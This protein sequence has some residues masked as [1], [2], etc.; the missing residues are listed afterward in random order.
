MVCTR[1]AIATRIGILQSTHIHAFLDI[2][3]TH[4][5]ILIFP[6]YFTSLLERVTRLALLR[7]TSTLSGLCCPINSCSF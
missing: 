4:Q 5:S 7:Q 6:I 1:G 3:P 2:P